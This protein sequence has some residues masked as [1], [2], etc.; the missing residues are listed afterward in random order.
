[1][2][3]GKILKSSVYS[4]KIVLLFEQTLQNRYES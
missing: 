4:Y 1:M 3:K 2:G